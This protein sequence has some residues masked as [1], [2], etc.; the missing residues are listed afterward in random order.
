MLG[1]LGILC[2]ML[3]LLRCLAMGLV[4]EV[5]FFDY[6][7]NPIFVDMGFDLG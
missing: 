7:V 3:I 6:W 1:I 5:L 2:C 4:F